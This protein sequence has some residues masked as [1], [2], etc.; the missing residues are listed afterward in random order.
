MFNIIG[1]IALII[2]VSMMASPYI[3]S[4]EPESVYMTKDERLRE[5]EAE[6]GYLD[7]SYRTGEKSNPKC[8][9]PVQ[10]F[11]R[12]IGKDASGNRTLVILHGF[13]SSSIDFRDAIPLLQQSEKFDRLLLFDFVGFG[14]SDKPN[15]D[16]F[17]YSMAEYADAALDVLRQLDVRSAHFLSHDMGDSVLTELAA[18]QVRNLLS[19]AFFASEGLIRSATFTNGGMRIELASFRLS[20]IVLQIPILRDYVSLL[21]NYWI[22]ERQIRSISGPRFFP[23]IDLRTMY[24]SNLHKNGNWRF[25]LTISYISDRFR[26]QN[27]RYIPALQ[28]LE[29]MNVPINIVWGTVDTVAPLSIAIQ[30]THDLPRALFVPLEGLGHFAMLEDPILWTRSVLSCF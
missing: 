19:T 15:S 21:S 12:D 7:L 14:L 23:P 28:S 16:C 20:Q 10:I 3:Q 26:F 22:F 27:Q 9:E 8:A 11:Y 17:S 13:P 5:W 2:G 1:I 18:R 30:L 29:A 4:P 24:E 6:G 25:P